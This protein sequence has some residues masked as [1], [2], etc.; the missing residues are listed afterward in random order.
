MDIGLVYSGADPN[1][2]RTRDFVKEFVRDRGILANI[3]ETERSVPVPEITIDGCRVSVARVE[4]SAQGR[5]TL[6]LLSIQELA[7]AL[8]RT[9]WSL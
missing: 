4:T 2:L 3:I 8:E 7:Q 5:N 9:I 6:R 1:H